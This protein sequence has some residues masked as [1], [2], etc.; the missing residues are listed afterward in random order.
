MII[1]KL[2][3][4]VLLG[5][6]LG[7]IPFGLLVGRLFRG[8]DVREYGSGRTGVANIL[9]T[10]GRRA[11]VIVFIADLAKGAVAVLLAGLIIGSS[12]ATLGGVNLGLE[13]AQVMAAVAAIVGHDWSVFIRFQ[14]GRGVTTAFGGLVVMSWP[15]AVICFVVF[16]TLVALSRYVSVGSILATASVLVWM[17]LLVLLWG[18]PV[19]YIVYGLLATALIVFQHRDNIGRLLAGTERK[20]GE[21][22]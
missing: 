12:V 9:R 5:Y 7:S 19:E 6:L 8:V 10:A 15:V 21:K 3:G 20:L 17:T 16:L 22:G 13:G 4:V 14:G 1:L 18:G 2:I 11:G